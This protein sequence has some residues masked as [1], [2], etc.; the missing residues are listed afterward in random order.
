MGEGREGGNNCGAAASSFW[1]IIGIGPAD[2][3]TDFLNISKN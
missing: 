1:G 2:M 3:Y